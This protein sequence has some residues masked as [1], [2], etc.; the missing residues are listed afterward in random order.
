[1]GKW[2]PEEQVDEDATDE[3]ICEAVQQ[4]HHNKQNR[5]INNGNNN[6]EDSSG[7]P[8]PTRKEALQA[9]SVLSNYIHLPV[10]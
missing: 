3:E 1:V 10:V 7:G 4:M 9:V 8:K 6:Q 5:E 2:F